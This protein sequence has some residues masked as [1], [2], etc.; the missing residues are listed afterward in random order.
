MEK[1]TTSQESTR[2]AVIAVIIENPEMSQKVNDIL[3]EYADDIVGRMG[4]PY[5]KRGLNIINIVVDAPQERISALSG[6]LGR[7]QGVVSKAI[8]SKLA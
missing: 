7:L 5:R 2:V 8:Y 6:K 4:I 3:H 1:E